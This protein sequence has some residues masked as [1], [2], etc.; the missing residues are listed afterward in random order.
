MPQHAI[1]IAVVVNGVFA[2]AHE[3]PSD[4][5]GQ[6]LLDLLPI[7]AT[8]VL[9]DGHRQDVAS[10]DLVR[11]DLGAARGGRL[12]QR[13]PTLWFGDGLAVDESTLTGE[14]VPVRPGRR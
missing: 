9:R 7:R 3:Y 11:D 6:C 5:A 14:S 2:F 1:T 10:A 8:V 4:R 12:D 13:G